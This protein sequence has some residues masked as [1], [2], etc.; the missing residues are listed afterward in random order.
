VEI[1]ELHRK[2]QAIVRTTVMLDDRE[3]F[4]R[5]RVVPSDVAFGEG[6]GYAQERRTLGRTEY[7]DHFRYG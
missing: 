6:V 4:V 1:G 2:A 3:V 7:R 5:E